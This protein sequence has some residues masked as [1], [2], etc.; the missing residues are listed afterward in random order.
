MPLHIHPKSFII[1]L[2]TSPQTCLFG[3]AVM[4]F[5]AADYKFP[6]NQEPVLS[7]EFEDLL[8]SMTQDAIE[9]RP[10]A[11]DVLKVRETRIEL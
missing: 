8:N 11:V 2:L 3:V 5:S 4:L 7:Q 1:P 6:Q 10:A 9:P